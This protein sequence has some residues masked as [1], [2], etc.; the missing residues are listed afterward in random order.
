M[1]GHRGDRTRSA[2]IIADAATERQATVDS[3]VVGQTHLNFN[4]PDGD[5]GAVAE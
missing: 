3:G 1:V 5:I 2:I 4:V